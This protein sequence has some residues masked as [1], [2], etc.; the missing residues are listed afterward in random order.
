M[1]VCVDG[2]EKPDD[3]HRANGRLNEHLLGDKA[4]L[5]FSVAYDRQASSVVLRTWPKT[6]ESKHVDGGRS[7]HIVRWADPKTGLQV[8]VEAL[9]FADSPVLE[10]TVYFKNDGQVDAPILEY[11]QALDVSFP[12]AG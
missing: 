3:A 9:E 5:P 10:W 4:Q 1:D 6:A 7:E 8:R 12:V 2:L 11:V